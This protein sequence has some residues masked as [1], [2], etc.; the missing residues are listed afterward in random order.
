MNSGLSKAS[1]RSRKPRQLPGFFGQRCAIAGRATFKNVQDIHVAALNVAGLDD[2]VEQ[3]ACRAHEGFAL[4]IF[5]SAGRF[6]HEAQTRMQVA[7]AE[8]PFAFAWWPT[9]DTPDKRLPRS[10]ALPTDRWN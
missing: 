2:L 9:R 3:L 5:I 6:A 4:L 8:H 7:D 10:E 1:C